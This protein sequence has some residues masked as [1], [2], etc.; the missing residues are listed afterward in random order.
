MDGDGPAARTL[1]PGLKPPTAPDLSSPS[2]AAERWKLFR[3]KW[4]N[5][6]VLTS[7][8]EHPRNFQ[9]ALL[10]HTL[11]DGLLKIYN[12]FQFTTP[13]T[14]RTCQEI[15]DKFQD[16]AVGTINETYERFVFNKRSQLPDETFESFLAAIQSQIKLCN[17]HMDSENSLLRDR[18]VIGIRDPEV[19]R[20]LLKERNLTLDRCIDICKSIQN[21][22]AQAKVLQ[23]DAVSRITAKRAPKPAQKVK[24]A[25][26][27]Q[28]TAHYD[29]RKR[30]D[31]DKHLHCKFCGQQ[32]IMKKLECPAWG[33]TCSK[34]NGKNHFA[35]KCPKQGRVHGI[36]DSEP[37]EWINSVNNSDKKDIR[38]KML[39]FFINILFSSFLCIEG[40]SSIVNC[41][42]PSTV[43]G[44]IRNRW[45]E[46]VLIP[47]PLITSVL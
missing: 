47:K 30:P 13:D 27:A 42:A 21:A 24:P 26:T 1:V 5:Y 3:Q 2:G 33:K 12:G 25:Y 34:C 7:M 18:I 14:E 16:F 29:S 15:L 44:F 22:S 35:V 38:C 11:G 40:N 37:V 39:I 9:V 19:Q 28:T 23:G 36:N 46:A 4:D 41:G 31:K 17:Y 45:T 10:L 8:H 32:H 6:A 43:Y 20:A